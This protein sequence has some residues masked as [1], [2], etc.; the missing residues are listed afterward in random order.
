MK[1][2][3]NTFSKVLLKLFKGD[4]KKDLLTGTL[5]HKTIE[6]FSESD[7]FKILKEYPLMEQDLVFL[8]KRPIENFLSPKFLSKKPLSQSKMRSHLKG[9]RTT[10]RLNH[11][12]RFNPQLKLMIASLNQAGIG[13]FTI[14]AYYSKKASQGFNFHYDALD[15]AIIGVTG[16]KKWKFILE[17][18]RTEKIKSY[19]LKTNNFFFIPRGIIHKAE[20]KSDSCLHLA[21]VLDRSNI[22]KRIWNQNNE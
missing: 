19:I 20:C 18:N 10:I 5:G 2:D 17:A 1:F 21:I 16:Q 7:F 4:K 15:A 8:E 13:T 22:M 6:I 14:N 9:A 12:W 3:S 11:V